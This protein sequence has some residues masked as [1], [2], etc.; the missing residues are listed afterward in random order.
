MFVAFLVTVFMLHELSEIDKEVRLLCLAMLG[1]SFALITFGQRLP[2]FL[3]IG[4]VSYIYFIIKESMW[5]VKQ[6][7]KQDSFLFVA[8]LLDF[9]TGPYIYK[10]LRKNIYLASVGFT[11][12]LM[13]NFEK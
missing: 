9:L 5:T 13:R 10:E 4:L 3:L 6:P 8:L 2:F 12:K 7:L 1:F 11:R